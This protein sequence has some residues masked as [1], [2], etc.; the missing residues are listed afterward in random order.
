MGRCISRENILIFLLTLN[1]SS[2]TAAAFP[3]PP[4]LNY[5]SVI[6][7]KLH[8]KPISVVPIFLCLVSQR[9]WRNSINPTFLQVQSTDLL[10][11][12]WD[13]GKWVIPIWRI[14]HMGLSKF[15]FLFPFNLFF[16]VFRLCKRVSLYW[17]AD[18]PL[19][20]WLVMKC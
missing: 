6:F 12:F 17:E 8:E 1:L 11:F 14:L 4:D 16:C 13:F 10:N 15:F 5:S 2:T 19:S 3:S 18:T 20:V 7:Q 9:T